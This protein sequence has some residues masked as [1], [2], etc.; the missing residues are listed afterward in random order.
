MEKGKLTKLLENFTID[1]NLSAELYFVIKNSDNVYELYST[2]P[3]QKL[4][5]EMIKSYTDELSK[6]SNEHTPYELHSIYNDN[7]NQWNYLYFDALNST[8]ISSEV[9]NAD[10]TKSS[11]YTTEIGDYGSIF[12]FV[13]DI[14]NGN[15]D[16][17][18]RIFKKALPTQAMRTSRVFGI[19]VGEDGKFKSMEKDAV[20]FQKNVD[21]FKIGNELIIKSYDVYENS[22]KFDE[23]LKRRVQDSLKILLKIP[24]LDFTPAAIEHI[25]NLNNTKRKKLINCVTNNKIIIEE[26]YK[27]I[28][29]QGKKY[30]KHEFKIAENSKIIINTQKDVNHLI[31]I[32][33]REINKNSATNEVF[34]TP[35]K[36][37][38]SVYIPKPKV[39]VD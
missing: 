34:H 1:Q 7:E 21:L 16:E 29:G 15:K 3:D 30:L 39:V 23:I 36:K 18:V 31:T 27:T 13:I 10:V 12:G 4:I 37:L 35:S 2:I 17:V 28:T 6:F 32:L 11:P 20:F 22:F 26:K 33:N 9:F 8:K 5:K 19:S 38:L 24:G 14:Y 25:S